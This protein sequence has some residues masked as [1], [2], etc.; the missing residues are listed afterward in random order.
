[1]ITVLSANYF[2]STKDAREAAV[3]AVASTFPIFAA[4]G[5]RG[6]GASLLARLL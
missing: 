3:G 1:M 4:A 5:C 2:S 6:L